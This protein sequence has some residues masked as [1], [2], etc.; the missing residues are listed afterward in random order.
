MVKILQRDNQILRGIANPVPLTEI[1]TTKIKK[2]ITDMQKAMRGEEDA[3][4]IAAPQIGVLLRIFVVSG[5]IFTKVTK[6]KG[7]TESTLEEE[8]SD[9][10]NQVLES[11]PPD[12]VLINPKIIK[13]S[14]KEGWAEEGC[15]SVRWW[16]GKVKRR[17]KVT[18][19]AY[20]G[21]GR[22]FT[23]GTSGLLAQIFQHEIDHL[24]GIL[25]TDKAKELREVYPNTTQTGV[26]K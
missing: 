26:G 9:R 22:Q 7:G 24:D 23:R 15:L 13:K 16:Y 1:K 25:F 2:V 4:A 18:V 3:V 19:L 17:E 8:S 14:Q 12:L 20:D 21:H 11:P 10:K 5:K 6:D